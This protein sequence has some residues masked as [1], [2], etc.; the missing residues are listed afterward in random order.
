MADID[1]FVKETVF[2]YG[3]LFKFILEFML[4]LIEVVKELGYFC[5][6]VFFVL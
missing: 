1:V 4:S 6:F 3:Y 5:L 2:L